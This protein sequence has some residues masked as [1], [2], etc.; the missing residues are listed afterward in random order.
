VDLATL[1]EYLTDM[2][3][4]DRHEV[5]NRLAA[6]LSHLLKWEY[7]PEHRSGSWQGTILEQQRELQQ[8]LESGALRNHAAAIFADTYADARKQAAAETGI[9]R[10]TFPKE[11]P[12]DL[13]GVLADRGDESEPDAAASNGAD[14][15]K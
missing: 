10:G 1:A 3:K 11:C 9:S 15:R 13:A 5:F 4:R 12:W 6:F 8:L 14:P 2:G 7:Q